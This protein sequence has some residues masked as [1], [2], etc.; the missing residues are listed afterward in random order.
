MRLM[1]SSAVRRPP[2]RFEMVPPVATRRTRGA[3]GAGA[4]GCVA[5]GCGG[6]GGVA[7]TCAADRSASPSVKTRATTDEISARIARPLYLRGRF[8]V[9]REPAAQ[10]LDRFVWRVAVEGH[11]RARAAG[12]PGDLG[13]PP[14]AAD[15]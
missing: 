11:H 7:V 9:Q 5:C 2:F 13:S 14:V 15:R 6:A 12:R 1:S 8:A 10:V 3:S 4:C